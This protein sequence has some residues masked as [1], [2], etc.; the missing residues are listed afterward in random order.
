MTSSIGDT[1]FPSVNTADSHGDNGDG[2]SPSATRTIADHIGMHDAHDNVFVAVGISSTVESVAGT[3]ESK[4]RGESAGSD[5]YG[6]S[7]SSE[8]QPVGGAS[9]TGG[10]SGGGSG[11]IITTASS[12]TEADSRTEPDTGSGAGRSPQSPGLTG[13]SR[14]VREGSMPGTDV[15]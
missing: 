15:E 13:T 1:A 10:G 5:A 4:G 12:V 7:E 9:G 6:R 2:L 8:T 11:R 3:A 14:I